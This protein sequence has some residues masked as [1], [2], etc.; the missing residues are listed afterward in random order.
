MER[1]NRPNATAW[2]AISSRE[3]GIIP[4]HVA[5]ADDEV[6]QARPQTLELQL[7]YMNGGFG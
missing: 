1:F 4:F 3:G 7:V 2:N 6:T 5:E